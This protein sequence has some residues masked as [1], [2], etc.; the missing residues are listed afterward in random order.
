VETQYGSKENTMAVENIELQVSTRTSG[1]H[2]SRALRRDEKVPAVVYGP[3]VKNVDVWVTEKD[4]VK[5]NKQKFEN[6][7][8]VF[9]SEDKDLNNLKVLKK[10]VDINPVSRRPRHVDFYALDMT[11]AV[12]VNV[13]LQ[14]EGKA[15]G[16]RDGGFFNEVRREV[17]I[18]TLPTNIPDFLTIDISP[19]GVGDSLHASDLTVPEGMKLI[20]LPTETL[21]TIVVLE[22]E[23]AQV[24]AA[25]AAGAEGAA[26]APGA[27]APG[28]APAA[29]AAAAPGAAPAAGAKAPA[30]K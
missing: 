1:K 19:L 9:K 17:E 4:L 10:A 8:F 28:A 7:I 29:G 5:Y 14:F 6:T 27:A 22:E 16:L 11:R 30:K 24:V 13:K 18:E 15:A 25:P 21:C 23:A 2:Y 20:T 3:K 26:A 12:R